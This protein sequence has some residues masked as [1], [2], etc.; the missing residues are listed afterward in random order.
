MGF[1]DGLP[2]PSSSRAP[3]GEDTA[4][5]RPSTWLRTLRAPA[6][7]REAWLLDVNPSGIIRKCP[8][9]TK[10][11]RGRLELWTITTNRV[12]DYKHMPPEKLAA[13]IAAKEAR[14]GE[15]MGKLA[16]TLKAKEPALSKAKG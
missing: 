16:G 2:P 9:N 1:P 14:I 11:R 12:D 7:N 15:T 4:T 5:L 6:A 10:L 13:D 8:Q 3:R